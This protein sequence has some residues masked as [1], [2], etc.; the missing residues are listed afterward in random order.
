MSIDDFRRQK[1]DNLKKF[2]RD[3]EQNNSSKRKGEL[4]ALAYCVNIQKLP[5][6]LLNIQLKEQ[7]TI[8]YQK[9]LKFNFDNNELVDIPDPLKIEEGWLSENTGFNLW[10]PCSY[11][12]I[13]EYLVEHDQKP[14]ILRLGNDYEEGKAIRLLIYSLTSTN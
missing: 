8:D 3:R 1:V 2:L 9:L 5:V 7:T 4:V 6:V 13:S 11:V 12:N 14:L 10:P